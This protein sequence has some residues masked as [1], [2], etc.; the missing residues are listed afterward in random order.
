MIRKLNLFFSIFTLVIFSSSTIAA[1]KVVTFLHGETDTESV[2]AYEKIARDFEKLNP[3]IK[4]EISTVS[5]K[6]RLKK[7]QLSMQEKGIEL[8]ISQDAANINYLTGYDAWS[9]YYAQCVIVHIN[10]DEPICFVRAQDAG[11]AFIKTYLKKENI[12]IYDE[13]YIHTWPLHP[14]DALVHLIKK[15][16]LQ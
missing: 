11:G 16:Y 7:V 1:E 12:I 4:I 10:A 9:F 3:G 2:V 6:D 8:S 13:K 14:Y 5:S 15:K